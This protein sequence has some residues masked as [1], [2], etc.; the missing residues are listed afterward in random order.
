MQ[1]AQIFHRFVFERV[2]LVQSTNKCEGF[3]PPY[4]ICLHILISPSLEG[5]IA[6]AHTR[7]EPM[8]MIKYLQ[9][10]H[11]QS[12]TNVAR[13]QPIK[14]TRTYTNTRLFHASDHG[15][16]MASICSPRQ[17]YIC[18]CCHRRAINVQMPWERQSARRKKVEKAEELRK[19]EEHRRKIAEF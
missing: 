9:C 17:Q 6:R 1:F 14:Q 5:E 19:I 11:V 18:R 8:T 10:L 7:T 16:G 3:H 15:S 4:M 12:Q 13:E 2:W